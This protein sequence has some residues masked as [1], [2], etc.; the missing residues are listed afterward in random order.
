[1]EEITTAGVFNTYI[2]GDELFDEVF[3]E[4]GKVRKAYRKVASAFKGFSSDEFHTLDESAK[5]SFLNQGITFA[6][7]NENNKGVERIFPFDLFPR[8]IPSE[9]WD[10][11]RKG[12]IQRNQAINLFLHDLYHDKKI[13]K[14][15]V[16]PAELVFSSVNYNKFMFDFE[17]PASIYNHISGTDIIRHKD[18]NYYVLEDNVRCPSGV[19][20]VLGNR[21]AMKKTLSGIFQRTQI[22]TIVEYPEE[23]LRMLQSVAPDGIDDPCCVVLTPGIHNSAYYEHSFLAQSMGVELVESRD[24]FV[25]KSFL[26]MKT[27][28]GAQKVDVIYRRV[29]DDFLDPLAFNPNSA[30]GVAGLMNVYREGNISI[31][32]APGTGVS[33]DKAVYCYMPDIIRYYL[34]EEPII[35][36]VPTYR[37]EIQNEMKYV[38]ENAHNLVIKPVDQSGG[39]GIV[40]G[41][42]ASKAELEEVKTLIK[43]KPRDYVAQPIMSLTTHA[44]YIEDSNSFEPRHIDLRTFTLL[45]KNIEYVLEGG[46]SRV[47]LRKGSLIVNSSQGGGSKDTWITD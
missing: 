5:L 12:V 32:N 27:I 7:Y 44:T 26:Y 10:I 11:I 28:F 1:M 33:D 29:D 41:S 40:I 21:E 35:Q 15:K 17:P 31:I 22:R 16:V 8:I 47:A 9:E 14:D 38:L 34:S 43:N 20:Y 30:L 13:L 18:G 6:T 36:N 23:L 25:E 3:D 42:K 19:S 45:G 24:L 2:P 37:C 4:K 46:L 39:Y